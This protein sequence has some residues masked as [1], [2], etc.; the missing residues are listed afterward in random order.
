MFDEPPLIAVTTPPL[1]T[2]AIPVDE[3]TQGLVVAGV[4]LPVNVKLLPTHIA[5]LPVMVGNG[6]TV[7]VLVFVHPLP[8]VKEMVAVPAETPVTMPVLFTVATPVLFEVQLPVPVAELLPVNCV[9]DPTQ[10]VVFPVIVGSGFI[11]TVV[12]ARVL[13]QELVTFNPILKVPEVE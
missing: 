4:A 9:L 5:E 12:D 11:V 13:P 2:V 3:E 7:T 8:S 10:I 6:L 1:V